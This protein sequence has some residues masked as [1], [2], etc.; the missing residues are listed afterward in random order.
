MSG[1]SGDGI[2]AALVEIEGGDRTAPL[3]PRIRL[4]AS[5]T[6]PY[7]ESFKA[8]LFALFHPETARLDE[9]C[10]MNVLL[11]E[12]F[13][14]AARAVAEQAGLALEDVDLIGCADARGFRHPER[15]ERTDG[16]RASRLHVCRRDS[17]KRAGRHGRIET[18]RARCVRAGLPGSSLISCILCWSNRATRVLS[19]PLRRSALLFLT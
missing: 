10:R 17:G 2:G 5:L 14:K 4:I 8:R 15:S 3:S 6:V 11:A 16:L 7:P 18:G 1:T 19:R 13:A 12:Q 9:I